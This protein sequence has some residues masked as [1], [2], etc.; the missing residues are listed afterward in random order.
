MTT[1]AR[2]LIALDKRHL[3]HPYTPMQRYIEQ[4][5]PLVVV[6]AEG[7]RLYDAE[8]RSYVDGN[9]SWWTALLGH[10]HPRLVQALIDQVG[11]ME[12]VA[13][14]GIT[15]EPAVRLAQLLA[16]VAPAGLSRVFLSDNGSTAV[17]VALKLALQFWSQ[18]G[19]P[20]RT[21][22]VAL[23][24]AFHGETLGATALGGVEVFRRPFASVV[25]DCVHVP[26]NAAAHEHAFASLSQIV[27]READTLAAVV[28]E[29]VVQGAAGMRLYDPSLLARARE[30]TTRH[31]VLLVLDEVFTGYGRTGPFWASEHA[32]VTP[33]LCCT[34]KG[35]S[36][37]M[38]PMAATLVSE[39]IF[40]GFLGAPER[41]FYYGHTFC[42]NPLGAAVACEVLRVYHD[43][44]ILARARDKAVRLARG[45][46]GLRELRGVEHVRTLGMIGALDL[47][48]PAGYLSRAGALVCEAARRRGAYLRPLGNVVYVTPPLNIPDTDLDELL[49]ILAESI[50]EVL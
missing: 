23:E 43:E 47:A 17:E 41:A 1:R 45:F 12:H 4:E 28:L 5:S 13:L 6:R 16:R 3:W 33:D 34:A 27:E 24:G 2:E 18:N 9:A 11:R 42:G 48:G 38:L 30:V 32:G 8:G 35:F 31:D 20:E 50:R 14:A 21:R 46:E 49:H 26:R 15:H 19:R 39:R 22:F 36:G 40:Q 10:R 7:S 25:L 29:P 37:G 44:D